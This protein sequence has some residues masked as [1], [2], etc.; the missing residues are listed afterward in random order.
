M[1]A[2]IVWKAL[3][4]LM[5]VMG[6]LLPLLAWTERKQ[7]AFLQAGRVTALRAEFR[8]F[9]LRGFFRPM[10]EL[11]R[12]LAKQDPVPT[13]ANGV[14][15]LTAPVLIAL[16]VW[17]A[18]G[19]IPFAGVYS[20]DGVA[21]SMVIANPDWGILLVLM[22]GAFGTYGTV[23]AGW[24]TNNSGSLLASLRSAGQMISYQVGLGLSSV[25]LLMVYGTL[26][27]QDM[28]VAQDASFRVFVLLE[29]LGLSLPNFLLGFPFVLPAWGIFLQPLAFA[30]VTI[31]LLAQSGRSPFDAALAPERVAHDPSGEAGVRSGLFYL[32]E[33]V[34]VVLIAAVVTTLFL[35][36]WSLPWVSTDDVLGGLTPAMGARSATFVCI[37]LHFASFLVKL[38]LMIGVQMAIRWTQPRFRYDQVMDLCWKVIV[39]LSVLNI[40]VTGAGLLLMGDQA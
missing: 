40:F 30:L 24:S 38:L 25:G 31:C 12:R 37:A 7:A 29:K 35:G 39:P 26:Q 17:V 27:L 4:F 11:E 10:A 15:H 13:G 6:V 1:P 20:L 18:I 2:E 23:M 34:H 36:G 19:V 22:I 21:Q 16:P 5:L 28:V 33:Q 8:S 32:A 3:F 9:T 14:L